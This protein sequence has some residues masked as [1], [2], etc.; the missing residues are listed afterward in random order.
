M[1]RKKRSELPDGPFHLIAHA[2]ANEPLFRDDLDRKVYLGRLQQT[3][4][5]F[6]WKLLTFALMDTHVHALIIARSADLSRGLWWLHWKY[7]EHV[8]RRHPETR[9]HVFESRPKTPPIETE[10]HLYAVLR[11]IANN[12]V[13]AGMCSRPEDHPWSAHRAILGLCP[14]LPLLA[15]GD[16]LDL[17]AT[18]TSSARERYATFVN[19]A[20]PA[21]HEDVRR[22]SEG[23]RV[24][25]P[26]LADLLA[27]GDSIEAVRS[28][29]LDWDYSMVS[30]AA[31]LG[32][33]PST[34][35][36]RIRSGR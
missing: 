36:R 30:I 21:G 15:A 28:A 6:R 35:S 12:P 34:I 10:G 1:A 9:G 27:G 22:W 26:P 16:V 5:W 7:A 14:P 4:E 13:K 8:H 29:H 32:V 33:S 2:V 31:A 25:R 17:F 24:D 18:D 11:Y 3:I 19:G 23:P 20:D